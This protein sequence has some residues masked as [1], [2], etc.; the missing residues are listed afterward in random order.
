MGER[1]I[2]ALVVVDIS[3]VDEPEIRK[4]TDCTFEYD[5]DDVVL[6]VRIIVFE[7]P[8]DALL[9]N[10]IVCKGENDVDP[11]FEGEEEI[12]R[13]I[14]TLAVNDET[15]EV[16]GDCRNEP[17]SVTEFVVDDVIIG[18]GEIVTV[19]RGVADTDGELVIVRELEILGV[20]VELEDVDFVNRT[21]A[22]IFDDTEVE[23]VLDKDT[24]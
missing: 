4:D 17:L 9:V 8:G 21:V 22:V 3:T 7:T 16:D 2:E 5:G 20:I 13:F 19:T 18:V 14:D 11:V 12:L 23:A 15:T 24:I 6:I 1:E 10:D